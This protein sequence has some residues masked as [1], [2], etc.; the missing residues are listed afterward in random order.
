MRSPAALL[1]HFVGNV[2]EERRMSDRRMNERRAPA[3][4]PEAAD[5]PVIVRTAGAL[6]HLRLNRPHVI[7]ALTLE[8][9]NALAAGLDR[10]ERDPA[11]KVVLIDGAG[12]RGLCAGGDIVTLHKSAEDG[13]DA[14]WRFWRKEYSLNARIA[15]YPKPIVAIMDGVVMGGG[16]GLASH[17]SHRLATERLVAAMPEVGIG[18]SPDVGGSWLL[19][20]GSSQMGTHVALTGAHLGAKDAIAVGLADT[21]IASASVA[22][23]IA[24]LETGDLDAAIA[25]AQQVA[26]EVPAAELAG[27]AAWIAEAYAHDHVGD[28]VEA[29]Q[30]RPEP[31]ARAAAATI[32]TKSPTALKVTLRTLRSARSFARLEVALKQELRVSL[33][34]LYC[35]DFL[36]GVRAQLIDKDRTPQ[37]NPPTL[38]EVDPTTLVRFFSPLGRY[39]LDLD[40]PSAARR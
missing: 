15:R 31:A 38:A 18:F 5:H 3:A 13:T 25:S 2:P 10:F 34:Y 9:V 6:G 40:P 29:L 26:V 23:L 19:S 21:I 39:D 7:N 1:P 28:I 20:R 27:A 24:E 14:A 35:P 4:E 16:I 30:A 37:W 36:E 11:I 32:L 33:G 22:A 17:A 12:D 8:M